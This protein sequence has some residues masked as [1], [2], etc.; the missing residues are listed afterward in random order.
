MN[1]TV[2]IG[3]SHSGKLHAWLFAFGFFAI[4]ATTA[5]AALPDNVTYRN[6]FTTRESVGAIPATNIWHEMSYPTLASASANYQLCFRPVPSNGYTT[7]D[8]YSVRTPYYHANIYN[9]KPSIDGW[10]IPFFNCSG[11]NWNYKL[12]ASSSTGVG[13]DPYKLTA[14]MV[15]PQGNSCFAFYYGSS[16]SRAGVVLQSLRNE[17]TN[18]QVRIQ[19]D[20]RAP[21]YWDHGASY[22]RVFPVYD[23]HMDILAW[24]GWF[25]VAEASPGKFGFRCT[26]GHPGVD[27]DKTYPQYWYGTGTTTN[28]YGRCQT[29]QLGSNC[30]GKT[31]YWFRYVVTYDLDAKS[32]GG[33]LYKLSSNHLDEGLGHPTFDTPTPD[34][35]YQNFSNAAFT[36]EMSDASGGIS[37]IGI[38]A[39]GSYDSSAASRTNL[40]WVDN[41]RVSWKDTGASDFAVC[42]EN[43]FSTRRYRSLSVPRRE[44]LATYS[45]STNMVASETFADYPSGEGDIYKYTIVPDPVAP[46]SGVQP[47]GLDGWRILPY[48]TSQPRP[49]IIAYGGNSYDPGGEGGKML[50]FGNNGGYGILGQTLGTKVSSGVVKISADFRL[51]S[52]TPGPSI[53]PNV[54]DKMCAAVGFGSAALYSAG[55]SSLAANLAG[56]VGYRLN[57]SDG[58]AS[59]NYVPYVLG[60]SSGSSATHTEPGSWTTPETNFWYRLEVTADIDEK[61]YSVAVTPLGAASVTAD[62]APTEDPILEQTEIPFASD[63]ADIGSFYIYGF[64]YG[65]AVTASYINLRVCI[66]NIQV[67][68]NGNAIYSNDFTTSVRGP[69]SGIPQA[70]GYVAEQY[71][72]DDGQD[73]WMR[74]NFKAV[75]GV[76]TSATVRE[77]DGNQYLSL[78]AYAEGGNELLVQHSFGQAISRPFK[79]SVDVR[80]PASWNLANG[81][82]TVA[83]GGVDM[84]DI[85]A[86]GY[87]SS[88]L[89][90][91]GFTNTV[92]NA[93]NNYYCPWSNITSGMFCEGGAETTLLG[94][95]FT[96]TSA[97]GWYRFVAHVRPDV[98]TYDIAVYDM[99][100]AHPASPDVPRGQKIA[101]AKDVQFSGAAQGISSVY[102]HARGVGHTFGE[103]GMDPQHVSVDNMTVTDIPGS[104]IIVF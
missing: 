49:G 22:V 9:G 2:H 8:D 86:N 74:S 7:Y 80:P 56:G 57:V 90:A 89:V 64:G 53:A 92:A 85:S 87:A 46:K 3:N 73:H 43:D 81:H 61:K 79:F 101:E 37:G 75:D 21:E 104:I 23:R 11:H 55:N 40:V 82:F 100:K 32:F 96:P 95:N 10:F 91:F 39:V 76:M 51:P 59:T 62:F 47:T 14:V 19:V 6:D 65:H 12:S 48:F 93:N 5:D 28:Y 38:D 34:T 54:N 24:D 1:K 20:M 70:S 102:L 50:T 88:R 98:G 30:Y 103:V 33:N 41:I 67:W 16:A 78:G 18:G 42:Y 15:A 58:G 26:D 36:G 99:G 72:R 68:H 66:D 52:R 94:G 35:V 77:D 83:L 27:R 17:F 60:A 45:A 13:S 44:T 84:E 4:L 29:A 69:E 63:V 97:N 71:D 31:N 25:H